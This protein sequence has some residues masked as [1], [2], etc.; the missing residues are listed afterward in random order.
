M[1][2]LKIHLNLTA[3]CV[4]VY[5]FYL[6][7]KLEPLQ[8]SSVLFIAFG[9]SVNLKKAWYSTH[10]F[11]NDL[12]TSRLAME[13]SRV[14]L[15]DGWMDNMQQILDQYINTHTVQYENILMF[16]AVLSS[17]RLYHAVLLENV[18]V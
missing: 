8:D 4:V 7:L 9:S 3:E 2:S 13:N 16:S 15:H 12:H 5:V 17:P 18:S 1:F 11:Q 6:Y 10:I 14:S